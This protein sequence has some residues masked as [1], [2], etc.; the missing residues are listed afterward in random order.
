MQHAGAWKPTWAGMTIGGGKA[1]GLT[2]GRRT[3]ALLTVAGGMAALPGAW[4]ADFA[5]MSR[6][7][8]LE[9][10]RGDKQ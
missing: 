6:R 7:K 9:N 1:A 5:G 2:G 4:S 10:G 3:A 8:S